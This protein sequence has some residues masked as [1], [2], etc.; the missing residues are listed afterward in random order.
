MVDNHILMGL[1]VPDGEIPPGIQGKKSSLKK[2]FPKIFQTKS[3]GLVSAPFLAALLLFFAGKVNLVKN[4]LTE[5]Y[6]NLTVEYT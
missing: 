6:R 1:F 4:F 2:L 5:L 3:N